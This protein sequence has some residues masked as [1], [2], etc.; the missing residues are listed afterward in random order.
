MICCIPGAVQ[1]HRKTH[2][3]CVQTRSCFT[4]TSKWRSRPST[5]DIPPY[6]FCHLARL[7]L[8]SGYD[9]IMLSGG[10][11]RRSR[12]FLTSGFASTPQPTA[13]FQAKTP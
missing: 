5:C 10:S 8:C 3:S 7:S 6:V 2:P 12:P 11:R 9:E 4:T 1:Y 13:A